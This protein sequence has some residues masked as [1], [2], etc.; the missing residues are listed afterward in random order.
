MAIRTIPFDQITAAHVQ[1]LKDRGI[2]EDR[3]LDY[4]EEF[5]FNDK[6]KFEL[7][8]DVSAMANA[9]GG[10]LVYG[11]KEGE[12]EDRGLIVDLPGLDIRP[13]EAQQ[14][15]DNLLRDCLDELVPEIRHAAVAREDDRYFF[16]IRVPG[17]PRAPHMIVNLKTTRSRFY[18]RA[19]TTNDPMNARQI[20]EVALRSETAIDRAKALIEERTSALQYR[21]LTRQARA[22]N[23]ETAPPLDQAVLHVVPL[24]PPTDALDFTDHAILERLAE[25]RALA[26]SEPYLGERRFSLEGLYREVPNSSEPIKHVLFLRTG[27]IE[28]QKSDILSEHPDYPDEQILQ[29]FKPLTLEEDIIF[30]VGEVLRL[31]EAGLCSLPALVSLRLLN[32]K[33]SILLHRRG[34]PW[35]ERFER[36]VKK[37]P[38]PNT[39]IFLEPWLLSERGPQTNTSI[40]RMFDTMWQAYDW[41]RCFNYDENGE[42]IESR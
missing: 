27:A 18:L 15:V 1:D 42:R 25:V 8:K 37:I 19:N 20:K 29:I 23:A 13:E 28:F 24:F 17:S 9:S 35:E 33:N 31:A 16:V 10:T 41:E 21:A 14:W 7:L 30:S 11:V 26:A 6:A 40:R 32:V 34:A 12:D 39:D 2:R 3:T 4:K 36:Q 38:F 5:A 22:C